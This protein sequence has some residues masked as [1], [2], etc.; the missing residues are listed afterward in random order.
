MKFNLRKIRFDIYRRFRPLRREKHSIKDSGVDATSG[1]HTITCVSPVVDVEQ[2]IPRVVDSSFTIVKVNVT[3]GCN[4]NETSTDSMDLAGTIIEKM[5]L[6]YPHIKLRPE[7]VK[8]H[9][10]TCIKA[11]EVTYSMVTT[12]IDSW[13][14]DLKSIPDWDRIGGELLLR[15]YVF[16]YPISFMPILHGNNQRFFCYSILMLC[17]QTV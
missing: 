14:K 3:N 12:V 7:E 11:H 17:Q 4:D 15:K 13:E 8:F 2:P 16:V 9:C 6:P 10:Q 5:I 1:N